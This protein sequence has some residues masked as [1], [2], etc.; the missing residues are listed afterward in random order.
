MCIRSDRP[1]S[2]T[3]DISP[4][5][6]TQQIQTQTPTTPQVLVSATSWHRNAQG[7]IELIIDNSP[8]HLQP[9]LT[10]VAVTIS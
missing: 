2:D 8:T 3:H 5:H 4:F 6:Q 9:A 7:K 1:W 10:G